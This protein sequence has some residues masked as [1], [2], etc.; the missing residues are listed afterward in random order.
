MHYH[1]P[2]NPKAVASAS[3]P[4]DHTLPGNNNMPEDQ[5]LASPLVGDTASP[6]GSATGVKVTF[7]AATPK[8]SA[9]TD[10]FFLDTDVTPSVTKPVG[11]GVQSLRER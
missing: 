3:L 7:K 5:E 4:E 8:L 10:P 2:S 6:T 11:N 9:A 1:L